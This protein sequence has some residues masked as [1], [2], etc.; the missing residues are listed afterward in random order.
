LQ[1]EAA[2]ERFEVVRTGQRPPTGEPLLIW[3]AYND[4]AL[5]VHSLDDLVTALD[6]LRVYAIDKPRI[7]RVWSSRDDQLVAAVWR[8][9][10][11]LY[12]IES[13]DGY[14]T[15][16]G[17]PRRTDSFEVPHY[18]GHDGNSL[19][20]PW[21]DCVPWPVAC[22]ALIRFAAHG[23]L[24]PEIVVEGRIP[25]QLLMHGELDRQTVL[26]MRAEPARDPR[27]S[28]LPRLVPTPVPT[29]VPTSFDP[30]GEITTAMGHS[31]LT[32]PMAPLSHELSVTELTAWGR[33]LV[34]T[35]F[36]QGLL[37]LGPGPGIDEISYQLSG[38][39]HAHGDDAEHALDTADWLA[40]EM[41]SIRGIA[42]LFATGGDLQIALR[43][44]RSPG[45][46]PA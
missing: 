37:E 13:L 17:D 29:S 2:G 35:L 39:L 30:A 14:A 31:L 21:A 5:L 1:I 4:D 11:A 8:D 18:D 40:H 46:A 7:F 6:T 41:G 10:C 25:S 34:Q 33:R 22:R 26:A 38:L 24:G 36:A 43:R 32:E 42:K 19:I 9:V 27:S 3:G 23:E 28:S 15:S 44:S 45:G 16:T 12:I 20:V